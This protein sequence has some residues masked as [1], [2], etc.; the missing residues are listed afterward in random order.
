MSPFSQFLLQSNA[1][2]H[3]M[4]ICVH[5]LLVSGV[6]GLSLRQ[7]SRTGQEPA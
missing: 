7:L 6:Q 3:I 5:S 2:N 4:V 1:H